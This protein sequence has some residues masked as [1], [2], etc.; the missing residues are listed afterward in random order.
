[1]A[2]SQS[3]LGQA[4]SHYR[5]L[6]KLGGGGMGVV[7]KA[8]DTRLHR[9]VAL[10][11]LPEE[12][13]R[14]PQSLARFQREAQAASALNH[15]NIC[16]IYDIGEQDGQAFIAME[17]LEG[18]TLKHC[19][20]GK[21]LP[22]EQ[23]VELA[24]EITDALEAAHVKGIVHR[25]IKPA[26]IFVTERGHSKI[27]DFGL[28][29][30]TSAKGVSDKAD[31]L[32]TMEVDSD[33]LTSPGATLGTV[34]Y[35]SP[36]QVRAE[37][38]DARTDIFSFGAVLYQMATGL[39][40]FRGESSGVIFNAILERAPVS[41]VRLNP[42][43]P[44]PLE[45]I[46]SKAL[47]K[48]R[49]LRYQSAAEMR[50]DLLRL[51]RDTDTGHAVA[52][53]SGNVSAAQDA[54][55]SGSQQGAPTSRSVP[56]FALPSSAAVTAAELRTAGGRKL[57]KILIPIA[58]LAIA[59]AGIFA[60]FSR[61]L[62]PPRVLNTVQ[63]THD[64]VSKT[65]LLTDGSRLYITESTGAKQFL[66]QASVTGGDTSIIPTP[67]SSTVMFDVSPDHS[68]LLV[69]D[70][71]MLQKDA[72]AWIL[73]LPTGSPRHLSNIVAHAAVWSPDGRQ[74]AFAKGSDIF[75]TNADGTNVRKLITVSG[76]AD[77]IRF[78]P[79]GTRLR[80]T[81]GTPQTNS[82]SLWEVHAD[83]TN[84]HSLLPAWN[85]PTS[86][87]CGVWSAD[88][89]YYFFVSGGENAN[90]WALREPAG[91]FHS[92]SSK[93]LQL[94]SGPMSITF[95]VP[96]PDGRKLFADGYVPRGE[97]VVYDSKSHQFL[98]FLSGI[99]AG[100]L[101]F[102]RD[103]KWIV[104]VS[105]PD[106][107]LWRSR[108]DGSERVQLTFPPT[109]A[110]L[111]HWS[112]D[113]TQIVF[114]NIQAGQPWKLF[115][116]SPQGGTPQEMLSEKDYQVDANWSLDGTKII[117][118][119]APFVP[120]AEKGG[121]QIFDLDSKQ[122]FMISGSENLYSPRLSPDG[123]RLAALSSD[124]K[125]L[126]LFDFTTQRW[127]GSINQPEG[128][129]FPAWSRDGN[130]VYYNVA[131]KNSAYRRVKVGQTRSELFVDS[132]NLRRWLPPWSGLTPD[133]SALFVRDVSSDE[134]YS[135]ELELP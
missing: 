91:L 70:Y 57:W 82:P 64:G 18:Q 112:P 35:M 95:A 124:S 47:E 43:V 49:K 31:T 90:L 110:M 83:G 32:A 73:P 78:S 119:R 71:A 105:Y 120:G 74:L 113:G 15:S 79:D 127:T 53:R 24:I 60:W 11:F 89:R 25:D 48:D 36:E 80:F 39:L 59:F 17:F 114:S 29:K 97:L 104:Y 103:G 3:L 102:S 12:V 76:S 33:H 69:A 77:S 128:I 85:T 55:P 62:P 5:I 50:S 93:P 16:T 45:D 54:A 2:D 1:M 99:S 130:Y 94:T 87:C 121:I 52:V 61:P 98:P 72:Q 132:K 131:G 21:P 56:P 42:D 8:E 6:E 20:A 126:W 129:F 63:I 100:E 23:V 106:R 58:M 96:S 84:L 115:L 92:T 10:K 65:N 13:A 9:F 109:S 75:L 118:G 34:A 116:I 101:D 67:F 122:V 14:D 22:L 41:P 133:G 134:I 66:V 107:S 40:P 26:N 125:K 81:L 19:I 37:D 38:L 86:E 117:F 4:I 88:G 30:V 51:K 7:Y 27:L 44:A 135:L 28:A 123:Q 46:I 68:Q 108:A 111:P